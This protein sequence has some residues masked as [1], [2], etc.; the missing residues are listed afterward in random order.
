M[1][2][3][4]WHTLPL[5][6]VFEKLITTQSGLSDEVAQQRLSEVG[7]NVLPRKKRSSW[8]SVLWNQFKSPLIY[9]LLIAGGVKLVMREHLD[10]AVILAA[11]FV[12]T[13]IGFIQENKAENAL[14]KL[15]SFIS[16]NAKVRRNGVYTSINSQELVPGDVITLEA[17]DRV[18]A[19]GRII[20][21]SDME[22]NE[23][24]LT[25]ESAPVIKKAGV[26]GKGAIVGDRS[27]MIHM[28]TVVT[29]GFGTVLIT[30]TGSET[31]IGEIASLINEA[32]EDPTPLQLQMQQLGKFLSYLILGIAIFIVLEGLWRGFDVIE[33]FETAIAVVVAAIPE[34]L[35]VS[36]TVILTL[37]MQHILREKALVRKL[38]ATE[39]LGS[40]SVICSDK[41]GTLTEGVMEVTQLYVGAGSEGMSLE[42]SG[43]IAID[44]YDDVKRAL[45]I[46]V[47]CN[48]ADIHIN[49]EEVKM[50]GDSTDIALLKGA[51][52]FNQD[53]DKIRSAYQRITELPFNSDVKYMVSLHEYDDTH[54]IMCIKG[55]PE[56]VIGLTTGYHERNAK[57][58]F[59]SKKKDGVLEVNREM[60]AQGL[61]V[62]AVAYKLVSKEHVTIHPIKDSKSFVFAGLFAMKDPLRKESKSTLHY[63]AAAGIRTVIITG[64]HKLTVSFIAQELGYTITDSNVVEGVELDDW[65]DEELFERVQHIDIYARVSPRHKIRIVEA[66]KKRG[67]VVAMLGDGVNDAPALKAA[68]IGVAVG[69]GTDVAK[70]TADIVLLDDNFKTIVMAIK[71][72][73]VIFDNIRKVTLY[74][75]A[76][77]FS[78][79][80]LVVLALAFGYPLPI[81]AIQ[82]LYINIITDSFPHLALAFEPAEPDVMQRKPRKKTEGI[83]NKEMKFLIFGAGLVADFILFGIFLYLF[84]QGLPMDHVRTVMFFALAFNT[85]LYVFTTKSLTQPLYKINVLNNK[86]LLLAVLMGI[87]IQLGAYFITP[88]RY[89]LDITTLT[90][91]D[92]I[93][94]AGAT[95]IKIICIEVGKIFFYKKS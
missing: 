45:E 72:G 92:W 31:Q 37:G 44:R 75:L 20:S 12:N 55:A 8:M 14:E 91:T 93:I 6:E 84:Y 38:V 42:P 54:N 48:D 95:F 69:S 63:T 33:I 34:G 56:V 26:V 50:M 60:T 7:R 11:V 59:S 73:R 23:A 83:I 22:I 39:T 58:I 18:P 61:R 76:S 35:V 88:L 67:E 4:L 21:A 41:T 32:Q 78:E 15:H 85:L 57:H 71:R 13:I 10:S 89:A 28:G 29:K 94:I 68:D 19:D 49:G 5:E 1:K 9:I 81:T 17:G 80:M 46:G 27:N 51:R 66:W 53:K 64:D 82:I 87:L 16:Y 74:L 52:A 79:V 43:A 40:T 90:S 25:G 62:L 36:I 86:Y 3:H 70:E 47:L 24:S 30:S 2:E 77:S 65:S